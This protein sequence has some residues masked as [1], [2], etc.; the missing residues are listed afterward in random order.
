M[1]RWLRDIES[2]LSSAKNESVQRQV[3]SIM[4]TE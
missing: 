4:Y 1:I 3:F 2:L